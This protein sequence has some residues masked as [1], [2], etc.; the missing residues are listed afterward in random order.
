LAIASQA[1]SVALTC[2]VSRTKTKPLGTTT[3]RPNPIVARIGRKR[4]WSPEMENREA[5][6]PIRKLLAVFVLVV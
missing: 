3:A 5:S 4:S 6:L 1:V 2:S